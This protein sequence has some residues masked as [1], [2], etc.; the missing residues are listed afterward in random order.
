MVGT[1]G[2]QED[3]HKRRIYVTWQDHMA[4]GTNLKVVGSVEWWE[5]PWPSP[6]LMVL[7]PTLTSESPAVIAISLWGPQGDTTTP[8]LPAIRPSPVC[9]WIHTRCTHTSFLHPRPFTPLANGQQI[10]GDLY[11]I[12][13]FAYTGCTVPY[14]RRHHQFGIAVLP[15]LYPAVAAG[16]HFGDYPDAY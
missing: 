1:T 3:K 16:A 5:G 2:Q 13:V 8:T 15:R 9:C 7:K 4:V 12:I 6:S 14:D 10:Y 11:S